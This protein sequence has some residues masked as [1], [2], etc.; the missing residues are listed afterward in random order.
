MKHLAARHRTHLFRD[1]TTFT[2]AFKRHFDDLVPVDLRRLESY[3]LGPLSP[4]QVQPCSPLNQID[5]TRLIEL[6]IDAAKSSGFDNYEDPRTGDNREHLLLERDRVNELLRWLGNNIGLTNSD[7]TNLERILNANGSIIPSYL[8][9]NTPKEWTMMARA[10]FPFIDILHRNED[11]FAIYL[12][13]DAAPLFEVD[14]YLTI[15]RGQR[16][17][18]GLIYHGGLRIN[19]SAFTTTNE[20]VMSVF[21]D[22]CSRFVE[23]KPW[24]RLYWESHSMREPPS[25]TL[26]EQYKKKDPADVYQAFESEIISEFAKR[27]NREGPSGTFYREA[28]RLYEQIKNTG[29][30]QSDMKK[31]VFVDTAGSGKTILYAKAIFDY[32]S[33]LEGYSIASEVLLVERYGNYTN[34][35][36]ATIPNFPV[37]IDAIKQNR[38]PFSSLGCIV[39]FDPAILAKESDLHPFYA[40]E[41][42]E[43]MAVLRPNPLAAQLMCLVRSIINWNE[44]ITHLYD[45]VENPVLAISQDYPFALFRDAA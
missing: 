31:V 36:Q 32:F 19:Y 38:G 7:K 22:V 29:A 44:S 30:L 20:V 11:T 14:S 28:Y 39:N 35:G 24:S 42:I 10:Y 21:R 25:F 41:I 9:V 2:K 12:G 45:S 1:D 23:E 17:R 15:I 43:G 40:S 16:K 4:A 18:A 8:L 5:V 13:R 34:Q 26:L 6:F 27:L 37:V 3:Y 33:R